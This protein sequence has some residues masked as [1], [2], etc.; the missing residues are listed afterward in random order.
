MGCKASRGAGYPRERETDW[1]KAGVCFL[2]KL[3]NLAV[4]TGNTMELLVWP[5]LFYMRALLFLLVNS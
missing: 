1:V 4:R 5:V 2:V 3:H